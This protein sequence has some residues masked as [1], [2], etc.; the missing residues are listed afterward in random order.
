MVVFKRDDDIN[1]KLKALSKIG[2]GPWHA[3]HSSSLCH[4]YPG[5]SSHSVSLLYTHPASLTLTQ[6]HPHQEWFTSRNLELCAWQR[7]FSLGTSFDLGTPK[8]STCQVNI[9]CFHLGNVSNPKKVQL[10]CQAHS[11]RTEPLLPTFT[12]APPHLPQSSLTL[13]KP[14]THLRSDHS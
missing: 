6:P 5:Y 11:I 2:P 8:R 3:S 7:S 10:I 14:A 1:N 13:S 12:Q 4:T 9:T